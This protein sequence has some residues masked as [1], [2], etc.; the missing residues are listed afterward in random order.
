VDRD[1]LLKHKLIN[2]LQSLG[3]LAGMVLVLATV[4]WL[5][6]G[7]ELMLW[8]GAAGVV[9]LLL[10]PRMSPRL[11]LHMYRARALAPQD[12]PQLHALLLELA[13]RAGLE[14]PPALYYVPS[15]ALNAFTVGRRDEAAVALTDG[16]LR[17]FSLRELAGVLA[18]E[19]S[20]VRNNDMWV[21]GLADL[22]T[23]LTGLLALAGQLLLLVGLLLSA[24]TEKVQVPWLAIAVLVFAPTVSA[25]LQL[26]LSRTRELD[27]DLDAAVLTGDPQGLASALLKLEHQGV[28]LAGRILLPGRRDPVPSVLRSHPHTHT[29]VQRLL[30]LAPARGAA[31]LPAVEEAV[32]LPEHY[33]VVLRLPRR[34]LG[35]VWH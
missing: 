34:H 12:A 20:H 23:R 1:A 21:M 16:M 19:I 7:A 31:P 10:A 11:I 35:G 24:V 8:A 14:H 22:A 30:A 18:H 29:R 13:R 28:G 9:V 4:G 15:R 6:G 25:L 5:L 33:P 27:A 3:L 26:A 17:G 2:W 32:R